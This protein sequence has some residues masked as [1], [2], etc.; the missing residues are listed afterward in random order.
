MCVYILYIAIRKPPIHHV[1]CSHT[2]PN[3][4]MRERRYIDQDAEDIGEEHQSVPGAD[5]EEHVG[6]GGE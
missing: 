4:M 1:V 3:K 5:G 6:E 2:L